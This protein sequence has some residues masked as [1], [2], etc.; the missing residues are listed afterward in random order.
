MKYVQCNQFIDEAI[1]PNSVKVFL[2]VG[3][4]IV[5][6]CLLFVLVMILCVSILQGSIPPN[7][8]HW[9]FVWGEVLYFRHKVWGMSLKYHQD[10]ELSCY[11]S[12]WF[13]SR[14]EPVCKI[15]FKSSVCY[16]IFLVFFWL[17]LLWKLCLQLLRVISPLL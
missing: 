9:R 14:S 16:Y 12:F 5:V 4:T 15:G 1:V 7:S 6:F 11:L 10:W 3:N 2:Y 13:C 8:M 17:F